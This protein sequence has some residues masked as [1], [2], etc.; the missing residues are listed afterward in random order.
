MDFQITKVIDAHCFWA[1]IDKDATNKIQKL[2]RV[3]ED[4]VSVDLL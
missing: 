2:S 3:I 1:F 4:Y